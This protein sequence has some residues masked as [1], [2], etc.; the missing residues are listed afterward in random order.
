MK[1]ERS[2]A[3][4]IK[5]SADSESI[6]INVIFDLSNLTPDQIAD[7]ATS[8]NGIRVWYQNKERPK[9]HAHLITLS[10]TTQTVKVPPCGTRMAVT[11]SND[12]MINIILRSKFDKGEEGELEYTEWLEGYETAEEALMAKLVADTDAE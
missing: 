11:L 9:G 1:L 8:A 4:N 7:W 12:Q 2:V 10:K 5:A 3:M 6:R